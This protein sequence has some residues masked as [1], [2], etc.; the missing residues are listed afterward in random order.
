MMV[1]IVRHVPVVLGGAHD[2][3]LDDIV[4]ANECTSL[5]IT[6]RQDLECRRPNRPHHSE[7]RSGIP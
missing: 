3:T 2:H 5:L 7:V 1:V 4:E 6:P